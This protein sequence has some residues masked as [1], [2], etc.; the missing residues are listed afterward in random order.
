MAKRAVVI[1][2]E[3]QIA[4]GESWEIGYGGVLIIRSNGGDFAFAAG[5]WDFVDTEEI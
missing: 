5:H 1:K 3:R 2:G 4:H